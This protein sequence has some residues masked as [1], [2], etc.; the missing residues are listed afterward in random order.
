MKKTQRDAKYRVSTEGWTFV[1]PFLFASA[2]M[3]SVAK[4]LI[5]FNK[6][7]R[8]AQDDKMKK[9]PKSLITS[10]GEK[11]AFAVWYFIDDDA[12]RHHLRKPFSKRLSF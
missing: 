10:R 1:C 9:S 11:T 6:I 7:L 4:H 2:V 3:L 12:V 5:R 8:L